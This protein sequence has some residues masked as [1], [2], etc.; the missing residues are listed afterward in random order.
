[1]IIIGTA[2]TAVFVFG[3]PFCIRFQREKMEL[4]ATFYRLLLIA[5]IGFI[6]ILTLVTRSYD[7][8]ATI[9][10]QLFHGFERIWFQL[11]NSFRK[12]G[13]KYD[14]QQ[15]WLMRRG[16][17]NILMNI[18]LFVPLGYLIP[19]SSQCI[20]T[21]WKILIIGFA[22]TLLIESLQLLTHRGWFD[23]DDIMFNTAGA[24]IGWLLYKR[25]LQSEN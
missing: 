18:I 3:F 10:L 8:E 11:S 4:G 14:L 21:W 7:D 24:M 16:I 12:Y 20:N 17:C 23:V 22:F 5:Y 9:N 6:I 1:M 25:L 15:F 2:L 19:L 13:H